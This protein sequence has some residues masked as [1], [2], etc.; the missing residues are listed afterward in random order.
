MDNSR[1]V[2]VGFIILAIV[3]ILVTLPLLQTVASDVQTMTATTSISNQTI[4]IPADGGTVEL[5]GQ[6]VVGTPIVTNATDGVIITSGNYTIAQGSGSDGQI[7]A[8]Y[9]GVGDEFAALSGNVS[10]GYEP[11]GYIG[12]TGGGAGRAVAALIVLFA[13]IGIAFIAFPDIRDIFK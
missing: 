10:Y 2:G 12:G 1:K 11:D 13:C 6:N 8:I 9:T 4:T 3:G 5:L 7:A